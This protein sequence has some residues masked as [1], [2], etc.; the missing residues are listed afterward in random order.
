[1]TIRLLLRQKTGN[2]WRKTRN[3]VKWKQGDWIKEETC[4]TRLEWDEV[5]IW[6][7]NRGICVF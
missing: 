3:E 4:R 1:M 5:H 7:G 6:L 2:S